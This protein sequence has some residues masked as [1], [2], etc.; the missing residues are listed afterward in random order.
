MIFLVKVVH[1]VIFLGIAVKHSSW[2]IFVGFSQSMFDTLLPV[3]AWH[4]IRLGIVSVIG[5]KCWAGIY[6]RHEESL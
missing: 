6:E 4:L 1:Y 3:T 2:N 5:A